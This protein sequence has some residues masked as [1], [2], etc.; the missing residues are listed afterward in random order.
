MAKTKIKDSADAFLIKIQALYY[1]E[2]ELEKALPKLAKAAHDPDL[3]KGF[4]MHLKETK[5]HGKRLEKIFRLLDS[6]PKKLSCDGID[7]IIKDGAWVMK[8]AAPAPIKDSM[9][10]AAAR[11]AE[12]YEIAGYL[13]AIV[14]AENLGLREAVT[15]LKQTLGEE[16]SCDKALAYGMKKNLEAAE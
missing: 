6:S 5:E 13:A 4:K 8:A 1:I 12:H 11:Y 3:A 14:E 9:I 7:G 2:K 15:L 10:A 16:E